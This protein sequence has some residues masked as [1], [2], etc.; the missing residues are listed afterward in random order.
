MG[1]GKRR[2]YGYL[3]IVFIFYSAL[4]ATLDYNSRV[5]YAFQVRDLHKMSWVLYQRYLTTLMPL[6]R[7]K[8]S[9]AGAVNRYY[10]N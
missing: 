2:W 4:Y 1:R 3:Y 8:V 5:K 6:D 7:D 10:F 9:L